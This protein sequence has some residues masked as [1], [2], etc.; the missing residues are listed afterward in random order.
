V[1]VGEATVE[2][3]GAERCAEIAVEAEAGIRDAAKRVEARL[4]AQHAPVDLSDPGGL[5]LVGQVLDARPRA[6]EA[7]DERAR[8]EG[9]IAPTVQVEIAGEDTRFGIL[10]AVALDL[11]G[12]R[13]VRPEPGQDRA[14]R[15]QLGVRGKDARR[16][17]VRAEQHLAARGIEHIGARVVAGAAHRGR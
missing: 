13:G 16:R 1:D 7:L 9:G 5:E 11:R 12:E 2:R 4:V 8:A 15:E 3:E 14:A 17:G 6:E 10:A